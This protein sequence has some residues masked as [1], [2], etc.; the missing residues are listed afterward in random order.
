MED[1]IAM[2]EIRPLHS[3]EVHTIAEVDRSEHITLGYRFQNGTLSSEE[4][5]W[6]VPRWT[7]DG[8]A[9]FNLGGR[10]EDLRRKIDSGCKVLAAFDGNTMVGYAVLREKISE[11]MAQLADLFVSREYRRCGIATRLA[12]EMIGL[13]KASGA[14]KLYVSAVPSE[15]AVGFYLRQGFKPAQDVHPELFALEP[16]DI[17]MILELK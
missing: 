17:H 8:V 7:D 2:I 16:E 10:I 12:A 11:E 5:N 14:R 4:V 9:E 15:S 6:N 13:A 1:E 3:H